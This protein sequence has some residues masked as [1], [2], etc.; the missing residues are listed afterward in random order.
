M[1]QSM[2]ALILVS[3]LILL[4]GISIPGSA[5]SIDLSKSVVVKQF[6][7]SVK[8]AVG[9]PEAVRGSVV[10]TMRDDGTFNGIVKE[11]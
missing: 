1:R 10:Q 11:E 3:L 9:L 2:P 5:G 6:T 7:A 8:G 4:L